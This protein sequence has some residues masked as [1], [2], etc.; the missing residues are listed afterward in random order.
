M[1]ATVLTEFSDIIQLS[2]NKVC[3]LCPENIKGAHL[4][5]LQC[6]PSRRVLLAK[7]V[8]TQKTNPLI[9]YAIL[10][11]HTLNPMRGISSVK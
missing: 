8:V 9:P 2:M 5:P 3:L 10:S 6:D 1:K 7:V 4:K 11:H